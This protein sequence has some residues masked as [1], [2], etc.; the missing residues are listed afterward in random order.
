LEF[1]TGPLS[2][3]FKIKPEVNEPQEESEASQEP[4]KSIESSE[5]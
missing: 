5:K 2:V 4:N 1:R 3:Q